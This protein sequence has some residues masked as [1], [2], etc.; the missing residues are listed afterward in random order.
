MSALIINSLKRCSERQRFH[1]NG[2]QSHVTKVYIRIHR[3]NLDK[4]Q[5][6]PLLTAGRSPSAAVLRHPLQRDLPPNCIAWS[7]AAGR[8]VAAVKVGGREGEETFLLSGLYGKEKKK[9]QPNIT[10][11]CP[12]VGVSGWLW[13]LVICSAAGIGGVGLRTLGTVKPA[14]QCVSLYLPSARGK[15]VGQHLKAGSFQSKSQ[16]TGVIWPARSWCC[17]EPLSREDKILTSSVVDLL[18]PRRSLP[19]TANRIKQQQKPSDLV[20]SYL[21]GA[22]SALLELLRLS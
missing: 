10:C 11:L 9:P 19:C 12:A 22:K 17:L 4:M 6:P 8:D 2:T 16:G 18:R 13:P 7:A 1:G 5:S 20:S 14:L 15:E 21:S 3:L